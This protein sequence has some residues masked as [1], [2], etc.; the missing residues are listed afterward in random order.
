[1]LYLSPPYHHHLS[2]KRAS[3]SLPVRTL[4]LS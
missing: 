2:L 3:R 4:L 1:M